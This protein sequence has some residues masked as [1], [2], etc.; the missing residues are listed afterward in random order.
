MDRELR[1]LHRGAREERRRLTPDPEPC[2]AEKRA[3]ERDH[4]ADIFDLPAPSD[5]HDC[6]DY[7]NAGRNDP[8]KPSYIVDYECRVC[9]TFVEFDTQ[10]GTHHV[11]N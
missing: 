5:P 8:I 7:L 9:G 4:R 6:I 11:D 10:D 2:E 3:D 1:E